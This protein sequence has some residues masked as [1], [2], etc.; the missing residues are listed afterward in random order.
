M[1]IIRNFPLFT[2]VLSLFSGVLCTMLK[3]KTA[4]IYTLVYEGILVVLTACVLFYTMK[5]GSSFTYTMGEF[6]AP[7]GNEIRAGVLEAL[8]ALF[9]LVI[10]FCSVMAGWK[11]L[12]IDIDV[13]KINLYFTLINLMTA[14]LMALVWTNDI[15]TGYVFVEIMTLTSCGIMIVREIGR[16]TLAAVRYM[17]LNLL[18]S[19]LFLLGIVLLYDITGHLLMI[20]MQKTIAGFAAGGAEMTSVMLSLGILTI[21]LSIKSGLFPFHFWMPDT[22]GWS[23]PTSGSILSSLVSKAYIFLLFKIYY[24][25]IGPSVFEA[26]PIRKIIFVLGIL[27]MIFGS[28]SAIRQK[29]INRMVAFSSAAQIGYIYLGLGIGGVDGYA[30]AMFQ[31]FAHSVTKSLLFL[32]TPRLSEVS[33][34]SLLFRNLQGSAHRAKDAGLFFLLCSLSMVGIPIF[35]GFSAKLNFATAAAESGNYRILFYTMIALAV[36]SVLNALYFIRTCIRIYTSGRGGADIYAPGLYE[37]ANARTGADRPFGETTVSGA[38]EPFMS[39]LG[40]LI[41]AVILTGLNLYLGLFSWQ[42]V[43]LLEK[44]LAMF[45]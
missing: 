43:G 18:G 4:K 17:I 37:K 33:G 19:G 27:G 40:Y 39:R 34:H 38:D 25:V 16:T 8:T 15:F 12:V 36:S 11:F 29:N 1:D 14:A 44:G 26:L 9:F 23:T 3:G 10:L 7:W 2:I 21:G 31:I 32:T 5:N 30:A 45:S 28:V 13:S 6:P 42:I 24:R 22:Y 35:A 41:P 20:P